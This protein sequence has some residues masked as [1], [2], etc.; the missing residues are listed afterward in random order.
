MWSN[1]L[2]RNTRLM[3]V[4]GLAKWPSDEVHDY[5]TDLFPENYSLITTLLQRSYEC[6]LAYI[7][8]LICHTEMYRVVSIIRSDMS[9]MS[10]VS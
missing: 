7:N 3:G 6:N 2:T 1:F 10:A 5:H 9:D 8:S 4:M